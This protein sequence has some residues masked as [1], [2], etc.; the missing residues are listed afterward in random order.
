MVGMNTVDLTTMIHVIVVVSIPSVHLGMRKPL[1]IE[2][3]TTVRTMT[4][5]KYS[6][7]F[8]RCTK[9]YS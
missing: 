7:A 9:G 6:E 1:S 3:S 2:F 4:L 5:W 8:Q